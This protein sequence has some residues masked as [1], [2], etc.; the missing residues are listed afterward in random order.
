M[1]IM[2]SVLFLTMLFCSSVFGCAAFQGEPSKV[3]QIADQVKCVAEAVKPFEKFFTAEL[4]KQVLAGQIDPV[5]YLKG[6]DISAAD[7]VKLGQDVQSC[8]KP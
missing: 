8:L 3:D 5:E 2:K 6:L 1:G 7:L 4:L